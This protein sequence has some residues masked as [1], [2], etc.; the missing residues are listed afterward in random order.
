MYL[1]I[2]A[3]I[4]ADAVSGFVHTV[5]G[6]SGNVSDVVDGNSMLHGEVTAAFGDSRH[7]GITKHPDANVKV[8]WNIAMGEVK[9]SA[10]NKVN[11]VDALLDKIEKMEAGNRA[12]VEHP[13]RFIKR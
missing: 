9:R 13:F 7:L 5:L 11:A 6:R 2:K 4:C 8:I 3:Y 1:C 12:K 10:L